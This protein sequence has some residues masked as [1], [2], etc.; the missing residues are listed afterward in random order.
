MTAT[1]ALELSVLEDRQLSP[2]QKALLITDGTV[3]QLLEAFA[4]EKMRLQKLGQTV[5]KGGPEW[6]DAADDEDVI[7]RR[8]LLC[9]SRRAYLFAESWLV[10]SR[11]P[12]G[13]HDAL[14]G[15]DT[16][17]GHIWKSARLETRREIVDFRRETNPEVS[18][19]LGTREQMLRRS[20]VVIRGCR[21]MSLVVECF[22]ADLF[23]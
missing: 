18:T 1:Q 20:Y 10:C 2:T 13:M 17:L 5:E 14:I 4:G 9:G 11:L 22:P 7:R 19:L 6:L 16:P 21:P 8:V 23:T 15:T 12:A 3:T